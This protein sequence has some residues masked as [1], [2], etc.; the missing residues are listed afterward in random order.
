[1]IKITIDRDRISQIKQ[2]ITR[3]LILGRAYK[4][5]CKFFT[6]TGVGCYLSYQQFKQ[7]EYWKIEVGFKQYLHYFKSQPFYGYGYAL[8][9]K[10]ILLD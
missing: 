8:S 5:Y 3:H 4:G 6:I 7:L 2:G 1:M 9:F 10:N